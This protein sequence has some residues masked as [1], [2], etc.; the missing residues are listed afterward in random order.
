[1]D[2]FIQNYT[3]SIKC[4]KCVLGK[5]RYSPLQQQQQVYNNTIDVYLKLEIKE[6]TQLLRVCININDRLEITDEE[7]YE[8]FEEKFEYLKNF[9]FEHSI[10]KPLNLQTDDN[11]MLGED[12]LKG[13]LITPPQLIVSKD[14]NV[15]I[16]IN[17]QEWNFI[18]TIRDC[19]NVQIEHLNRMKVTYENRIFFF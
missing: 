16:T 3:P 5:K 2:Y 8:I 15:I 4:T 19:I 14:E 7:W 10:V 17:Q 12:Y 13:V 11:M 18:E 9:F 1:M 6:N